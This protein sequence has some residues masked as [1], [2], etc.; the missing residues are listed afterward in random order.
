MFY[1][2]GSN[3]GIVEAVERNLVQVCAVKAYFLRELSRRFFRGLRDSNCIMRI[4][5]GRNIESLACKGNAQLPSAATEVQRV[6][7]MFALVP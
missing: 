7:S 5:G 6:R 3:N 4:V 2:V 1:Y